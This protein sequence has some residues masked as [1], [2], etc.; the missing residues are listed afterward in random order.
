[1]ALKNKNSTKI[2][3]SNEISNKIPKK[4]PFQFRPKLTK[5][6]HLRVTSQD[7]IFKPYMFFKI[8]YMYFDFFFKNQPEPFCGELNFL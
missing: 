3:T 5:K 7:R 1:M 8:F 6:W 4:I 2:E